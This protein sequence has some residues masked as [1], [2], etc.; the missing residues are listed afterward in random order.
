MPMN[1]RSFALLCAASLAA[2]S[3][4]LAAQEHSGEVAAGEAAKTY[5]ARQFFESTSFSVGSPAGYNFSPDGY[6][7]GINVIIYALTH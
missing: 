5:S 6:A 1:S 2:L 4:P 3:T 7:V